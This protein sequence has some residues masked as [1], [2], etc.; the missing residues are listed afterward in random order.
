MKLREAVRNMGES[1]QSVFCSVLKRVLNP[2]KAASIQ[3]EAK[4]RMPA[5]RVLK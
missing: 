2:A 4:P 1:D 5:C 3:A